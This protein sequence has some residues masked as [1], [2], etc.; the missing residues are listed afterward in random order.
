MIVALLRPLERWR[1][2]YRLPLVVVHLCLLPLAL[3]AYLPGVRRRPTQ[4]DTLRARV[5]R[6]WVRRLLAVCG[7]VLELKGQLPQGPCLLVANH[8]SWLDILILHTQR[9]VWLV[10]KAEISRWPLVGQLARIAGTL[11]I[12]RGDSQSRQKV[13]RKMTAL[14]RYGDTVGVF[15]E[16]GIPGPAKVGRFHARLFGSAI[17]AAVPVVPI[18]I[19]YRD[20][21]TGADAHEIAVFGPNTSFVVNCLRILSYPTMR[22]EVLVAEPLRQWDV[23]RDGL[24]RQSRQVI[25][26]FYE[27]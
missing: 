15:P 9:P 6:W 5:H 26:N 22:A 18:G 13:Q 12:E 1:I 21:K 27:S 19:R 4:G 8:V 14:L 2:A 25:E 11:F 3:M 10:A 17:R 16:A 7:V 20:P 24:A 23:G